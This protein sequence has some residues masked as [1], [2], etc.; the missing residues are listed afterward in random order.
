[1]RLKSEGFSTTSD[2][3]V[4]SSSPY[5]LLTGESF[6][7]NEYIGTRSSEEIFS[8]T[9]FLSFSRAKKSKK[10]V[11]EK[12]GRARFPRRIFLKNVVFELFA[13]QKVQKGRFW[14]TWHGVT[15][16]HQIASL[17]H[18]YGTQHQL[19]SL[20]S[21]EMP[22][23][24]GVLPRSSRLHL[25]LRKIFIAHGAMCSSVYMISLPFPTT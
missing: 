18:V 7:T 9:S 11:F 19:T 16:G 12:L 24:S 5:W 22:M 1:M 21:I 6:C 23:C 4:A 2:L 15:W 20:I 13:D 17:S 10:D 14:E 8:E 3:R 25:H